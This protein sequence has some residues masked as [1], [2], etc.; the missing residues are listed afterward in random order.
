MLP[1]IALAASAGNIGKLARLQLSETFWIAIL[2]VW[3]FGQL[4]LEQPGH[5]TTKYGEHIRLG[6]GTE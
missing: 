2:F 5:G 1:I 4:F 6:V 3:G